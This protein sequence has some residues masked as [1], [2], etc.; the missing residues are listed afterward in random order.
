MSLEA[1]SIRKLRENEYEVE[2]PSCPL[3]GSTAKIVVQGP[4][5]FQYHQGADT[6]V[7]LK[8]FDADTRERFM[9]GLCPDCFG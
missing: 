9:S 6:R 8:R 5:I 4:E 2:T 1:T 3:C 7:W